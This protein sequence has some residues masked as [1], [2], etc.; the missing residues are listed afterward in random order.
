MKLPLTETEA[1]GQGK[2]LRIYRAGVNAHP[3]DSPD[4]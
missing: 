2:D 1:V 4:R 3:G